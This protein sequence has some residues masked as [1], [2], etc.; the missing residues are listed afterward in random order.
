MFVLH[1]HAREQRETVF[2]LLLELVNT[3]NIHYMQKICRTKMWSHDDERGK[4]KHQ[5]RWE[6]L[7]ELDEKVGLLAQLSSE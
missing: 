4:N 2:G 3:V 1:L 6:T 7:V 5:A